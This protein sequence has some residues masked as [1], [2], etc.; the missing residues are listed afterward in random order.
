MVPDSHLFGSPLTIISTSSVKE[1]NARSKMCLHQ[2]RPTNLDK[3]VY[4]L[5]RSGGATIT[6]GAALAT[7]FTGCGLYRCD[8]F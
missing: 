4:D 2:W 8:A 6:H 1:N 7:L 5:P 3:N